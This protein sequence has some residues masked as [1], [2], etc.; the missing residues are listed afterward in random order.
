M[1]KGKGATSALVRSGQVKWLNVQFAARK[2]MYR[3]TNYVVVKARRAVG[4]VKINTFPIK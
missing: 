1:G 3:K 4:D 2:Y